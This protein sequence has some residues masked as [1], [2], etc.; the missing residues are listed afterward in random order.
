MFRDLAKRVLRSAGYVA[1]RY[2]GR[3]DP[4]AVLFYRIS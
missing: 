3:R 1:Q 4:D 2:E